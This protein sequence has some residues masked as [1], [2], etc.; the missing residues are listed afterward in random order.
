MDVSPN[1]NENDNQ[2]LYIQLYEYFKK[3]IQVSGLSASTRLPSIRRLSDDL[4][5]SKTTVQMAYQQL[6]AEGYIESRERSGFYVIKLEEE[7]FGSIL[8]AQ[9]LASF[10]TEVGGKQTRILYDFYMSNIDFN[11]FPFDSWRKCSNQCISRDHKDLLSYGDKQGERGLRYELSKYLRRARGVNCS[12]EQ[13]VIGSGTQVVLQIICQLTGI[14]GKKVAMEDPGYPGV[15]NVFQ[16]FRFEIEPIPLEEDGIHIDALSKSGAKMVYV[17]PSHQYPMGMVMPI[18]KRMKLLQWAE[19]NGGLIIE[20]DYDGEFRY[21]GKP[22]PSLQGLDA[23][24]N[25]VYVGTFSKSLLPGIRVSYMVLPERLLNIYKRMLF[26][27]DQTASRFHQKALQGF[28]ES[29]EW[30]RHIRRMRT[31]YQKKHT[32]LLEAIKCIMK[33]NVT[34]TGQDAGLHIVLKVKSDKTADQLVK[35]AEEAGVKV[36]STT[37]MWL[38]KDSVGDPLILLGFGGLS[39]EEISDGIERL[40]AAWTPYYRHR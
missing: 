35:I 39:L 10:K 25:V 26:M 6:L 19:E 14:D 32:A 16:H 18:A 40:N 21:R 37:P 33:T 38:K 7:S 28:I 23:H 11:H 22:I 24:G 4:K 20:D 9:P 30:E 12:E 17:T 1:L 5:I 27:Y 34:V 13:L 36:Y 8:P 2:P 31:I 15:R 29:G 3:Q